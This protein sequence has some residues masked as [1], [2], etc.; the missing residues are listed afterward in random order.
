VVARDM[1]ILAG[2]G[3]Y[4]AL[5]RMNRRKVPVCVLPIAPNSPK[6]IKVMTADNELGHLAEIDDRQLSELLK[7]IR[8]DDMEGLMGTG[9]DDAMLAALVT[10]TRPAS[11]IA[12][13]DAAAEWVGMPEFEGRRDGFKLIIQ[14][15]TET[16]RDEFAAKKEIQIQRKTESAWSTWWPYRDLESRK[17]VGSYVQP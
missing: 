14:F 1:T 4:Q 3:V 16:D 7:E 5:V 10:I 2:H 9:Y 15:E 6:A 17:N 12:G 13:F 11:E 8:D